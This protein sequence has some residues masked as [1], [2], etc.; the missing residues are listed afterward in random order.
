MIIGQSLI[1]Q[2]LTATAI[3]AAPAPDGSPAVTPTDSVSL[4]AGTKSAPTQAKTPSL[5]ERV[6]ALLSDHFKAASKSDGAAVIPKERVDAICKDLNCTPEEILQAI[7]PLAK[8]KAHPPVSQYLVGAAGLGKS[9][10]IYIGV[11]TEKANL[12][13]QFTTHGEQGVVNSAL[14]SGEREL[15][16]LAVSAAPCGHCRQFLNELTGADGLNILVPGKEPTTL[17]KELPEDFGPQD[18]NVDGALL[19]PKNNALTMGARNSVWSVAYDHNLGELMADSL[20]LI[21][22]TG[23]SVINATRVPLPRDMQ[24]PEDRELADLAL[25]AANRSYAPYSKDFSGV[26]IALHDGTKFQGFYS[27]NAAFNPTLNPIE[28]ALIGMV[29]AG[30]KWEEI[31]SAALVEPASAGVNPHEVSQ[32][33]WTLDVLHH[34]APHATLSVYQAQRPEA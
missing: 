4:S 29:L 21:G 17:P 14:T 8:T 9:G 2:N 24:P 13:L 12:T 25:A 27:E 19:S 33:D 10:N 22:D 11:N 31:R 16:S 7:I 15:T 28:S 30:R 23:Q 1:S 3:T 20:G 32:V 6:T 18:L 26:A 5:S 34:V